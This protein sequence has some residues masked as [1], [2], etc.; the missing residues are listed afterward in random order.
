MCTQQKSPW[1]SN[2]QDHTVTLLYTHRQTQ[3]NA[4]KLT[5]THPDTTDTNTV[6]TEKYMSPIQHRNT[7]RNPDPKVHCEWRFLNTLPIEPQL[8]Q[9]LTKLRTPAVFIGKRGMKGIA[10]IKPEP[11]CLHLLLFGLC[12]KKSLNLRISESG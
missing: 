12:K 1:M 4:H 5:H 6:H 3:R 10:L 11:D 8:G 2:C 9:R 7:H